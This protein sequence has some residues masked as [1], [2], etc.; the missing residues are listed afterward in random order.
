MALATGAGGVV[1]QN[2]PVTTTLLHTILKNQHAITDALSALAAW[3]E[4]LDGASGA[5]VAE[6]V[7]HSLKA[8]DETRAVIGQCISELMRD[9]R[10]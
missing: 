5:E 10:R 7:R 2:N 8:V 1:M 6:S 9:V 3:A 4:L